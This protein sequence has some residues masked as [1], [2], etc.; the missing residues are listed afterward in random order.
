MRSNN[1]AKIL[2]LLIAFITSIVSFAQEPAAGVTGAIAPAASSSSGSD[3][4]MYV[5][6]HLCCHPADHHR[7]FGPGTHSSHPACL[8]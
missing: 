8:Y 3:Y 7:Y 4:L 6:D 1:F 5:M 2:M